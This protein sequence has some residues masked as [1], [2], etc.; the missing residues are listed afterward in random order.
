ML[1]QNGHLSVRT[2]K[3]EDNQLLAKWLSD[4][5]VLKYYE[6]RDNPF[7][8]E[9]VNET[10]YYRNDDVT[11]C[12]VKYNR[13]PIGYIQYYSLDKETRKT[14]GYDE[15]GTIYGIDQFIGEVDYWNKGIGQLLVTSMVDYLVNVHQ[16][17]KVVMDPQTWNERAIRCYE[18]CGFEKVK[19]LPEHEYHE[20]KYR[21][22][23][24]LE[25]RA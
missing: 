20:G 11:G 14:Y 19:M 6:G 23:W 24:L 1:F 25:N 9:K 4:Q 8:L 18:K 3:R 16:A 21:D 17:E 7:D 5:K 2:L 15:T 10:F 13:E 22:C 12:L